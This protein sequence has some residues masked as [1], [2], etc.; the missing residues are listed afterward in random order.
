M[1]V[2]I[3]PKA[4]Y[5]HLLMDD[6]KNTAQKMLNML[7]EENSPFINEGKNL[8]IEEFGTDYANYFSILSCIASGEMTRAQIEAQTG[9]K[10]V[11]GYLERLKSHFNLIERHAPIFSK[12]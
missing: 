9:I 5:V 8:L 1:A 2:T 10:E 3:Q 6:G 7:T 11:G 12:P 4:W